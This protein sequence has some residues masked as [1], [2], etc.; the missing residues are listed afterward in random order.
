LP[1]FSAEDLRAACELL[2]YVVHRPRI[3][4]LL[5]FARRVKMGKRGTAYDLVVKPLIALP[6]RKKKK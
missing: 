2:P 1:A 3:V 5:R 4:P 6:R